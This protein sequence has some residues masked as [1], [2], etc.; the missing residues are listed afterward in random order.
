M[1][2]GERMTPNPITIKPE[3][4]VTDVRELMTREKVTHL[5]VV[6]KHG[7]LAG[8]V[9]E[10]DLVRVSP[11]PATSLS[12]WEIS[13]LLSR[14]QTQQVMTKKV[15]TVGEDTAIEDAARIMADHEVGGLPVVRGDKL[16]GIITESDLF[17]LFIELFGARQKGL[18]LTLLVPEQKGELA[19]LTSAIADKGGNLLAIGTFLGEDASNVLCTLKVEGLDKNTLVKI[20]KPL[21]LKIIDIREV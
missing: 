14:L 4:P 1:L 20:I 7:R 8:I 5:P 21:V 10:K 15:I 19:Q 12:I 6:D 18:R 16:V 9:T 13:S 3:T 17:K 2:V 11:S